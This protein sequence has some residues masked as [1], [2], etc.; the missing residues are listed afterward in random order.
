MKGHYP[1]FSIAHRNDF[2]SIC[3]RYNLNYDKF[4]EAI[5]DPQG[6]VTLDGFVRRCQYKPYEREGGE[7]YNRTTSSPPPRP[8]S[9]GAGKLQRVY[10]GHH[11]SRH[12]VRYTPPTTAGAGGYDED[13]TAT[14]DL[15]SIKSRTL[16][17]E[18]TRTPDVSIHTVASKVDSVCVLNVVEK[19][20]CMR[21][22]VCVCVCTA[23]GTCSSVVKAFVV[24][25]FLFAISS[26][27][28]K[29]ILLIPWQL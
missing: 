4:M 7:P 10:A 18:V 23:E 17:Q 13:M 27:R 1:L 19:R 21:A 16:R 20:M 22:C 29:T 24:S 26:Y 5:A 6:K 8:H 15:Q 25:K 12:S 2:A 3:R 14:D 11:Q 9:S 28:S